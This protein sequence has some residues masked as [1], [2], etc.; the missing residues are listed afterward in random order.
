MFPEAQVWQSYEEAP[1]GTGL[2]NSAYRLVVALCSG[3]HQF[4]Q[5]ASLM[6][7]KDTLTCGFQDKCVWMLVRD[8]AGPV[9]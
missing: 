6:G 5:D 9:R 8:Y 7:V 2:H 3:L 1:L 4:H